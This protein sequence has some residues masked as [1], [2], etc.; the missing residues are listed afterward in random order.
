MPSTVT[1]HLKDMIDNGKLV[2]THRGAG[3]T[4]TVDHIESFPV[5]VDKNGIARPDLAAMP[6][7]LD[8]VTAAA[9]VSRFYW[10]VSPRTLERWTARTVK[11][12][13]R[14]LWPVRDLVQHCEIVLASSVV[15]GSAPQK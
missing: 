15:G 2:P 10:P 8:K 6:A 4:A 3:A 13:G 14:R 7:R 9:F 1:R 12:G 11:A 5:T